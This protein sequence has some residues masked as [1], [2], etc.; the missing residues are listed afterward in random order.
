M[1]FLELKGAIRGNIFTFIEALKH[2]PK[3]T[4]QTI[5]TQVSRFVKKNLLTRIKRGLYCFDPKQIDELEL[6]HRLYQPSYI[7]LETALN[8][9]GIIPDI[10]QTVTSVTLTTTKQIHNQ[11]GTFSYN[12]IKPQLY[13]GFTKV[14]SPTTSSFFDLAQKEKALLDYF[15]LRKIKTT[16][17]LRLDL[18]N[19]DKSRYQQYVKNYPSWVGKL[20]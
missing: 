2:F 10:P 17:G 15:Y 13:F 8:F 11:F 12:K 7:S 6:A 5:K 16:K 20:I 18:K 1:K 3:E 19:L 4:P 14:K 9:Y